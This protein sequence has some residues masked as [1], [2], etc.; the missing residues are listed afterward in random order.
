MSMGCALSPSAARLPTFDPQGE[1]EVP[2]LQWLTLEEAKSALR[3]A[4]FRGELSQDSSLC[5]SVIDGRIVELGQVCYQH[6]PP[7]R[8]QPPKLPISVRIQT[9]DPR[10]G[11]LGT[12]VEW[13]LMPE[14][15][16]I[17][18]EEARRAL[19]AAGFNEQDRV[20]LKYVT[21]AGCQPSR[22]CRTY[23]GA[24]ERAGQNSDKIL[25]VGTP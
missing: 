14:V 23:P 10:H 22:I 16:G 1:I 19:E 3:Q 7:G 12:I 9:E 6:P 2:R 11:R 17:E 5:G 18:V 21:E 15:V 24:L 8:R 4:G 25:F 20:R 13:H